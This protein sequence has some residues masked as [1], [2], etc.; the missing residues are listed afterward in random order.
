[1]TSAL[2]GYR[3]MDRDS[4]FNRKWL[5]LSSLVQQGHWDRLS[6]SDRVF[7]ATN[8]LRGCVMRGGFHPYFDQA[9]PPEVRL[10]V[11]ALR[12]HGAP[13]LADLV[14]RAEAI[15]FPGVAAGGDAAPSREIRMWSEQE[16]AA[17]V[18][19]PWEVELDAV[20]RSFYPGAKKLDAIVERLAQD[21]S[22]DPEEGGPC[23]SG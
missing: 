20:N 11:A 3:T 23:R 19:P 17:G 6:D 15:L 21:D 18:T 5:E 14:E 9:P 8:H 2:R 13:E 22:G 7:Y 12:Q 1:L 4:A 10:A 16:L